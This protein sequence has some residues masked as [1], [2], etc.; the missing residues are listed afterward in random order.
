[1]VSVSTKVPVLADG[2]VDTL[3]WCSRMGQAHD[4]LDEAVLL[5]NTQWLAGYGDELLRQSLELAEMV[6]DLRL[7]QSAVLAALT[8]SGFR[9]DRFDAQE[10]EQQV[11]A[12]A[13]KL[14][15]SVAALATSSLLDV[16][17]A[18]F[19]RR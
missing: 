19:R 12:E 11:G 16:S 4:R 1:M 7:D 5:N 6:A 2:G 14:C 17:D 15:A 8:Y 3:Q 13:T 9:K 10:L 18:A